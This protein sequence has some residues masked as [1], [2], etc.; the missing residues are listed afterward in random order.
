[1]RHQL[2]GLGVAAALVTAGCLQ[3][4]TT[5]TIY[6]GSDGRIEWVVFDRQVRSDE[7]DPAKRG[8]EQ[9]AF[10]DAVWSGQDNVTKGFKALGGTNVRTQVLRDTVPYEVV[11]SAN[12]DNLG[13]LFAR[14][15]SRCGVPH[16]S[17]YKTTGTVTT[18]T[19]AVQ[20]EPEPPAVE[21][22][23]EDGP[24]DWLSDAINHLEVVLES[25]AFVDAVGF[26]KVAADKMVYEDVSSETIKTNGGWVIVSLT[27]DTAAR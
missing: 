1:M 22:C 7:S 14:E 16:R 19:L 18:W 23:D 2:I 27:W 17:E 3:K 26:T 20:V 25:G 21:G 4:D 6:V 24:L 13:K 11:R 12:F 5:S 8:A 10:I 15:L 9:Q